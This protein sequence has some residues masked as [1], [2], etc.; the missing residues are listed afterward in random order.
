MK[1]IELRLRLHSRSHDL[2]TINEITVGRRVMFEDLVVA[3]LVK[4]FS[5]LYFDFY[6]THVTIFSQLNPINTVTPC[7][8]R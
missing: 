5:V 8:L 2:R 3:Q 4:N 1:H 6:Q 7:L